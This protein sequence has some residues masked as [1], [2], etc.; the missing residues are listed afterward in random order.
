MQFQELDT[1][2]LLIDLDRM[3][4]NISQMADLVDAFGDSRPAGNGW[5]LGLSE[6]TAL[7]PIILK[8]GMGSKEDTRFSPNPFTKT[9]RITFPKGISTSG[10]LKVL[11]SRGQVLRVFSPNP[12]GKGGFYEIV[13]D[14]NDQLGRKTADL[15]V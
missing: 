9:I 6:Y 11:N 3:E 5:D 8:Q 15:P 4:Q 2:A 12:V 7:A 13:W 14:G 10:R 1:P